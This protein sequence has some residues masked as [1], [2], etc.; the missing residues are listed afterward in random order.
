MCSTAVLAI[1]MGK[2]LVNCGRT[3]WMREWHASRTI[4]T[5]MTHIRVEKG[6]WSVGVDWG[7]DQLL[8]RAP[9]QEKV[10]NK[11]KKRRT[12]TR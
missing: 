3:G 7:R 6:I 5:D 9:H 10:S 4:A 8:S 2:Q 12:T 1:Y 11:S